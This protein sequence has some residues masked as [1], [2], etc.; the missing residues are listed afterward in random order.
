MR[1][2]RQAGIEPAYMSGH[3]NQALVWQSEIN[4]IV[5]R[6]AWRYD[7]DAESLVCLGKV[8]AATGADARQVLELFFDRALRIAPSNRNAAVAS[9]ELALS[10]KDFG[11]AA[12]TFEE[13]FARMNSK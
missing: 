4:D 10:K 3:V 1:V 11:L 2:L 6:A 7:G 13:P 9:G 12:E 8:A 5:S